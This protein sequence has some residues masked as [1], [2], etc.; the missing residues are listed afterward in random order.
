MFFTA[1]VVFSSC[2][3]YAPN[4]VNVPGLSNKGELAGSIAGGNGLN[5][6]GAYAVSSNIGIMVNYMNTQQLVETD[7]IKR[8]GSGNLLEGGIGYFYNTDSKLRL[9]IYGG[10]GAGKVDITK[11][12]NNSRKFSTNANRIFLQPSVGMASKNFELFFTTRVANVN[13]S[14]VQSTYTKSDLDADNFNDI[15]DTR[16]LFV[17][18]AFTLR[19]GIKNVK[20]QLQAGR[21]IKLNKEKL[22][23]DPGLGSLGIFVKF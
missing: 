12:D 9:E 15:E 23:H 5:I 7:N 4:T 18:P 2:A 20:F 17:E 19:A 13:F 10:Y 6:Q 16:W 3:V 11:T 21:S 1:C 22:G 8:D 14:D